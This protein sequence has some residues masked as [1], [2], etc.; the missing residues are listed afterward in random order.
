M[1][2]NC[3][4]FITKKN[5]VFYHELQSLTILTQRVVDACMQ[6]MKSNGAEVEI[7]SSFG[8]SNH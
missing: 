5:D 1:F 7:D 8:I 6:S 3:A 4:K 2:E